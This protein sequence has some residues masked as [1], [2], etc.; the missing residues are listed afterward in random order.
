MIQPLPDGMVAAACRLRGDLCRPGRAHPDALAAEPH[1]RSG[2]P[3]ACLVTAAWAAAVAHRCRSDAFGGVAG[4]LELARSAA[5]YGFILHLYRR[6]VAAHAAARPGFHDHGPARLAAGRRHAADR[7]AVEPA[8]SVSLWSVGTAVR[9]GIAVCNILLIE[10]LY[11]NTPPDAR[12]HINLL[13][14][15]LGGLFLY[16][17]VLYSDAV[18]F[19]RVSRRCSRAGA[20]VDRDRRAADRHRRGAQPALG[21]RHPRLARRRLPQRDP[22]R[23]AASSCSASPRP[24]RSSA[25]AAPNGAMSPRSR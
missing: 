5:W 19:R 11:F 14:V 24:A 10:N 15:A 25:A 21:D 2:S 13:C 6:S 23:R 16:D 3:G 12:W 20:S 1:R 4:W 22:G 17:L 9:L 18:L 7:S 8:P